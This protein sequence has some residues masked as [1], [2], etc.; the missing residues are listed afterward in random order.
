MS[1][2][3]PSAAPL[4]SPSLPPPILLFLLLP[5]YAAVRGFGR[6]G[7]QGPGTGRVRSP[8]RVWALLY[9]AVWWCFTEDRC[10]AV[11]PSSSTA[12]GRTVSG[13]CERVSLVTECELS[14]DQPDFT[15]IHVRERR[16]K[17][18]GRSVCLSVSLSVCLSFKHFQDI[19]LLAITFPWPG[20]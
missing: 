13:T 19:V 14:H 15:K 12:R 9:S 1:S 17:Y 7:Q 8:W 2:P 11:W 6:M 20:K 18:V 16:A 3:P 5:S 4:L 10:P